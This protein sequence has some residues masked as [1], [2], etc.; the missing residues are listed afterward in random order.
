MDQVAVARR[1]VRRLWE[2]TPDLAP[3]ILDDLVLMVSELV[4]NAIRHTRSGDPGGRVGLTVTAKDG[5]ARVEV[6]DEG[7]PHTP[8]V[9]DHDGPATGGWGLALVARTADTW[10][11]APDGAVVDAGRVVWF[12]KGDPPTSRE[13]RLAR[14]HVE[15]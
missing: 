2:E 12:E 15:I 6:L 14:P 10:G 1:F 4:A 7:S 13:G 5:W 9:V 3:E 8:R 11:F